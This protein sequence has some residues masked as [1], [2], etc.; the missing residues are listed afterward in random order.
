MAY[1]TGT[2]LPWWIKRYIFWNKSAYLKPLYDL[3]EHM[4]GAVRERERQ[5]DKATAPVREYGN[6]SGSADK[7]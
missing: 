1:Q 2:W 7:V 4:S 5:A 3:D 6:R